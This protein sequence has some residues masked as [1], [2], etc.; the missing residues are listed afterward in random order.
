MNR[1]T[2]D[3]LVEGMEEPM[4][5]EFDA[6][7]RVYWILRRGGIQRMDPSTGAVEDL[8]TL[9]DGVIDE[10]GLLGLLLARDFEQSGHLYV[11]YSF[12][13]DGQEMRLSRFTLGANERIDFDSEIVMM[14]WPFDRGSHMGG[15]MTWD[16]EGN[17]YLTTGD[18]SDAT[19]YTPIHWTNEG[20]R[21]QDAQRTSANPNDL[22]GKI[23]RIHPEADGTYSIPEG[24]LF[25][26]DDPLTR[27]EIYIMGNRNP[28]RLS[29]DSKTGY[30]HWGEIGP[31][32]GSDS[33]G[34]GPRG[35]DE[36]NVARRAGNFG[37]PH[38]I[39][40]NLAYNRYDRNARRYGEPF[41]PQQPI[42]SSSNNTGP[43]ALPSAQPPL[44]AYP[45]AV[46]DQYPILGSGGRNAVGGP[47]FY[48]DDFGVEAERVFPAYYEGGWF[49]TDFVR[50]WVMVIRMNDERTEVTSIERFMP[51]IPYN[52][53]LDMDFSPT[54][55]LYVLEYGTQWGTFNKDARIS[56][57][58]YNDGNRAPVAEATTSQKAGAL[59]M[60]VQLSSSETIDFDQDELLY[61]WKVSH[62]DGLVMM[63]FEEP[64][65]SIT[66]TEA[67]TYDVTLTATDPDGAVGTD[68]LVIVAGNAPPVVELDVTD[69]N[70][71]FYF[72]GTAI[73]YRTRVSDTEDGQVGQGIAPEAVRV[74]WEYVPTGLTP[75]EQ[76][77]VGDL[78]PEASAR[79][80]RAVGIMDGSDCGVCH[81]VDE[82]SAGPAYRDIAQRYLGDEEAVEHLA[83][84]ILK[85]G[86]GVWGETPMPAHPAIT[87]A[88]A[89]AI[90]EYVLS[91]S[92]SK[93]APRIV[94]PN[95]LLTASVPSGEESERGA[96]VLR[97]SYTDKGATDVAPIT[98]SDALVLRYPFIEP[99]YAEASAGARFTDSRD[100]GFF[101]EEDGA[102]VGLKDIDLTGVDSINVHVMTRFYTWS[103]FVGGTVEIRLDSLAGELVGEPI[104]Q[105]LPTSTGHDGSGEGGDNAP[106]RRVYFGTDPVGFEVS[107]LSGRHSLY[108]IFWNG[109]ANGA[110]LFLLNGIEFKRNKL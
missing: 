72:P 108:I 102:Y 69:E 22:R 62:R 56:R 21:G 73:S 109:Q 11:Y 82:T 6:L 2:K 43:Q 74:T 84:K 33:A 57:I 50:N 36:L 97:A 81:M 27:P 103:H 60:R 77:R 18:N 15:G 3:V 107:H 47:I 49:V 17:L 78:S 85:G 46:S 75:E 90:T 25:V 52:S 30:L 89:Q 95:G 29:I 105:S 68:A 23:L 94:P 71:S 40:Y 106:G 92:N 98:S 55:D 80:L 7:G 104:L 91:F 24:N 5:L 34:V 88:E 96:F 10:A 100:P 42:N 4:Q 38:F 53:P 41:D 110:P 48:R 76:V 99:Q 12:L 37:W 31:D 83:K 45:Y 65:P 70:A 20:G 86:S 13:E 14:R 54:G 9:P 19:Q 32:A 87:K 16:E 44:I 26:D 1:F 8:G 79:H 101:I 67:G 63:Q 51:E 66:L 28:W 61:S 35:Y 64:N 59:P 58:V 93:T 39:G